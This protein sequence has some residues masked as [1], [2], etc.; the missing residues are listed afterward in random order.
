MT[1]QGFASM[2]VPGPNTRKEARICA[3][4]VLYAIELAGHDPE[5]AFRALVNGGEDHHRQF[6]RALVHTT[7][8]HTQRMDA[9]ISGK[10]ERWNLDRIALIDHI[11]LRMGLSE[12]FY[13]DDIPPKVTIN[14]AIELGK[15]FSTDQSGRFINGLLDGIFIEHEREILAAKRPEAI[16]AGA[17]PGRHGPPRK[18]RSHRAGGS[19]SG[20][21]DG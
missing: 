19:R 13:L 14:E 12:L 17:G 1:D 4:Q 6:C 3:L 2:E 21:G 18:P 7:H 15:Q 5:H 8:R 10:S 16:R 20:G 11:I 9:L